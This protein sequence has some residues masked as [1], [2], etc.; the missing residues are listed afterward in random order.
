MASADPTLSGYTPPQANEFFRRLEARLR[1]TPGVRTVGSSQV[2]LLSGGWDTLFIFAPGHSKPGGQRQILMNVT[3]GD[4]FQATGIRIL[5]GR[6]FLPSD[7]AASPVVAIINETGAR[8]F[9][10][11]D[12]PVGQIVRAGGGLP[13]IEIIGI[14][15]DSKY[16]SV[17]EEMPRVLYFSSEQKPGALLRASGP[18]IF[19]PRASRVAT[20]PPCAG[21]RRRWTRKCPSSI[22]RRFPSRRRSRW[23]GSG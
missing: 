9:F 10:E 18:S 1:D 20:S 5:R 3:G 22:S 8:Y 2:A 4:F 17:R 6:G 15:S 16:L 11:G 12:D 14:A 13:H 7:T 21:K 19:E 23:R